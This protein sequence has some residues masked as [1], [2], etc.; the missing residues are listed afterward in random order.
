MTSPSLLVCV[1]VCIYSSIISVI[2][3]IIIII[4]IISTVL[5]YN[6]VSPIFDNSVL[7]WVSYMII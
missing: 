3:I 5:F 1:C 4:I 6:Q 2:I 7:I